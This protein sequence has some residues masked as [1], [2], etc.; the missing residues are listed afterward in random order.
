MKWKDIINN[1]DFDP[2][3]KEVFLKSVVGRNEID[4]K[5]KVY[6]ACITTP[7]KD[8]VV[9]KCLYGGISGEWSVIVKV[10][11]HLDKEE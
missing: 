4:A 10:Y 3:L 9:R 6:T 5:N 1:S 11:L 8:R 2:K 7:I